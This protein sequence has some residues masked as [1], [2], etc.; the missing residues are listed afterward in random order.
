MEEID[1][2]SKHLLFNWIELK[3]LSE[4]MDNNILE[5]QFRYTDKHRP[6]FLPDNRT[7]RTHILGFEIVLNKKPIALEDQIR[8]M[9]Y[10]FIHEGEAVKTIIAKYYLDTQGGIWEDC[11][12]QKHFADHKNKELAKYLYERLILAVTDSD[13]TKPTT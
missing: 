10:A 6:M 2:Q 1:E 13:L 7:I 11:E 8:Y 5:Q 4:Q 9:E 3:T 12:S